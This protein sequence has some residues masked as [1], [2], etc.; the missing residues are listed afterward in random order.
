MT[1]VRLAPQGAHRKR[2][3]HRLCG[4][5]GPVTKSPPAVC[6]SVGSESSPGELH[7]HPHL[8]TLARRAPG[9]QSQYLRRN[10]PRLQL[11]GSPVKR[12]V[13][14][15]V[16]RWTFLVPRLLS[17]HFVF[18]SSFLL[19]LTPP[20]SPDGSGLISLRLIISKCGVWRWG[21]GLEVGH[22]TSLW[23]WKSD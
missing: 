17:V 16:A 19:W 20:L 10:S 1:S 14:W 3:R 4:R 8:P 9:I 11:N 23:P 22:F 5:R 6:P 2:L 18:P 15:E 12:P 21:T 7:P 13:Q